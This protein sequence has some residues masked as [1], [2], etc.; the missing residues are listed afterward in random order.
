L[1]RQGK[2]VQSIIVL[3]FHAVSQL[4]HKIIDADI[5]PVIA[6]VGVSID[7]QSL[8]INADT[9]AGAVAA[10][11]NAHAF[12]LLTDVAGVLDQVSRRLYVRIVLLSISLTTE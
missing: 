9:A 11:L 1:Q 6:P 10:A 5:V 8:N 7:G 4:L 2:H 3:S 12:L